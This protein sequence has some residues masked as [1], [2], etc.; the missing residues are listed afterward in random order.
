[1]YRVKKEEYSEDGNIINDTLWYIPYF[2]LYKNNFLMLKTFTCNTS[3]KT[4]YGHYITYI[5]EYDEN[6][7]PIIF[8]CLNDNSHTETEA[9]FEYLYYDELFSL[10]SK[11]L[12]DK[13]L[14]NLSSSYIPSELKKHIVT[15]SYERNININV[16]KHN[17]ILIDNK[18]V[19][20][21]NA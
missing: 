14:M 9:S 7:V 11:K 18:G 19:I 17:S 16:D 10:L 2:L 20:K 1:M 5:V 6:N 15:L 4:D 13:E 12:P 3:N 8:H 21:V